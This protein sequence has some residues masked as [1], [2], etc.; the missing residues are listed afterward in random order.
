M[1]IVAFSF[2]LIQE[3]LSSDWILGNVIL[4]ISI[5]IASFMNGTNVALAL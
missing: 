2:C 3:T 4:R 1:L 5:A